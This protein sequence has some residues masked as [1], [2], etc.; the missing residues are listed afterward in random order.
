[1]PIFLVSWLTVLAFVLYPL[2]LLADD[3][4]D[5]DKIEDPQKKIECQIAVNTT[6]KGPRPPPAAAFPEP[7]EPPL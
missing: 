3:K 7:K 6:P 4:K 5:C 2:S 1:M